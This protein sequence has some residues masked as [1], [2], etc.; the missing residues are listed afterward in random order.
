MFSTTKNL[1]FWLI[2]V[3]VCLLPLQ[4]QAQ[5]AIAP[6][7]SATLEIIQNHLQEVEA[8]SELDEVVKQALLDHYRRAISLI[9]QRRNYEASSADFKK[10]QESA[11]Q[12]IAALRK[13][14]AA[15]ETRAP[16]KLPDS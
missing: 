11:P 16:P 12:Q 4:L 10:A 7:S 3:C 15:L 14:V 2:L 13:E 9:E 1:I 5:T 6:D 8:S